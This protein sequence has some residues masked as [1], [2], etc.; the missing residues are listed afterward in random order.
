MPRDYA[1]DFHRFAHELDLARE[2]EKK[3]VHLWA[4]GA[5][6]MIQASRLVVDALNSGALANCP[7]LDEMIRIFK[8]KTM[9]GT[10]GK[11]YFDGE[12]IHVHLQ[13]P[14]MPKGVI[15]LKEIDDERA[16]ILWV[17]AIMPVLRKHVPT[18]FKLDAG[19]YDGGW[20]LK[21]EDGNLVTREGKRITRIKQEELDPATRILHEKWGLS[22]KPVERR[23]LY[24]L[25]D[26]LSHVRNQV[27][28]WADACRA[29][30]EL[31][32]DEL[33]STQSTT[34]PLIGVTNVDVAPLL[35]KDDIAILRVL[36]KSSIP[37]MQP[38][39]AERADRSRGTIGL[40]LNQLRKAGLTDRPLGA[41]KGESITTAGKTLLANTEGNKPK[42]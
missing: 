17:M 10:S 6:A 14:T 11:I 35:S 12:R 37:L 2:Q 18:A 41:R 9:K 27:G 4:R 5:R 13:L 32:R 42:E 39:I 7:E 29:M 22:D 19:K 36:S 21:D 15:S 30:A 38:D 40:R 1:S 8:N 23:E 26:W 31:L 33:A 34:V 20:Y 25:D 24:D 16:A 28:D 3:V